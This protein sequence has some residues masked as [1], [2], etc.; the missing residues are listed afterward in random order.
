MKLWII[1]VIAHAYFPL[2]SFNLHSA[3][4]SSPDTPWH[5]SAKFSLFFFLAAMFTMLR[6][7][8]ICRASYQEP[9]RLQINVQICYCLPQKQQ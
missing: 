3:F 6:L 9:Q 5:R 4:G 7:S 2:K 1:I 8:G